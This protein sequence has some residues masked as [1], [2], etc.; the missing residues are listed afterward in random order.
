MCGRR[1]TRGWSD[2]AVNFVT[3][4]P[5]E[6]CIDSSKKKREK[7]PL[8]RLVDGMERPEVTGADWLAGWLVGLWNHGG[9]R[10]LLIR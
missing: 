4:F 5:R 2:H 9:C 8:A 10:C 1:V 6:F 7:K 3:P